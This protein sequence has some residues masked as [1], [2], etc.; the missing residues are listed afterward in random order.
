MGASGYGS[1]SV[2]LTDA[3]S[4]MNL[5]GGLI[6]GNSGTGSLSVANGASLAV[7]GSSGV[8]V[9]GVI[10]GANFEVDGT[11][12]AVGHGTLSVSSQATMTADTAVVVGA[13]GTGELDVTGG[14]VSINAA[15]G[16]PPAL[17]VGS[18]GGS[19]GIV[20]VS[21][22]QLADT[23]AAGMVIGDGGS[24]TLTVSDG[25]VVLAG[26]PTGIAG[27][28]VGN[29]GNG[30]VSVSG[31]SS[32]IAVYGAVVLGGDGYG[33]MALTDG[34][35][36]VAG[37][38]ADGNALVLG[39]DAAGVFGSFSLAGGATASLAGQVVVGGAGH[40]VLSVTGGSSFDAT[41]SGAPA[42]VLGAGSD[43][44]GSVLVSDPDT[45]MT[46]TG[47]LQ[48]GSYSPDDADFAGLGTMTI[49]NGA[50]VTTTEGTISGGGI[51]PGVYIS[52]SGSLTVTGAGSTLQDNGAFE[53]GTLSSSGTASL[54]ISAGATVNVSGPDGN[55]SLSA[56]DQSSVTV[57]GEGSAWTIAGGLSLSYDEG[58]DTLTIA[59]GGTVS[60]GSVLDGA[61]AGESGQAT[62]LVTGNGSSLSTGTLVV[63]QGGDFNPPGLLEIQAGATVSVDGDVSVNSTLALSQG[64]LTSGGTVSIGFNS[65]ISGTGTVTADSVFNQGTISVSTGTLAF[66]GSITDGFGQ[67]RDFRWRRAVR[68]Q[69]C[70]KHAGDNVRDGRRHVVGAFGRLHRKRDCRVVHR[71]CGRSAKYRGHVGEFCERDAEPVR[72]R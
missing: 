25:G 31:S 9:P 17:D 66:I 1:G 43:G 70:R 44:I 21:G 13:F 54:T 72:D 65:F 12:T 47:G 29:T 26:D 57:T 45:Q 5:S 36:L 68:R 69:Q 56:V 42:M 71:G 46:L 4:D 53:V 35:H 37:Y 51:V 30:V 64:T 14:D 10:I 2:S 16:G 32:G 63:G 59:N 67:I 55:A 7:S 34:A 18:Q 15:P 28:M 58:A 27:L 24:G 33:S 48:L 52:P 62:I 49:Q 22:G 50:S 38:A 6:V 40:G 60:A 20:N 41:A 11:Y 19:A 23:Q 3:G 61:S 39:D 8:G